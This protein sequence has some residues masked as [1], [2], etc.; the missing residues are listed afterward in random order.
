MKLRVLLAFGEISLVLVDLVLPL[1]AGE[2]RTDEVVLHTPLPPREIWMA[3][4]TVALASCSHR[5]VL[6]S[7]NW[8][9]NFNYSTAQLSRTTTT[10]QPTNTTATGG[11]WTRKS[12]TTARPGWR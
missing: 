4:L 3:F 11:R 9:P 1:S 5:V 10:R 8:F 2:V 6:L 12:W 7:H